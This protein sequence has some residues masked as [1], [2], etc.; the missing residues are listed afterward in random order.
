MARTTHVYR[1]GKSIFVVTMSKTVD[2]L[3]I[4]DEPCSRLPADV[5]PAELGAVVAKS[6]GESRQGVPHPSF[7]DDSH[8]RPLPAVSG[9]K[10]WSTFVKG[11]ELAVVRTE[12]DTV[13]VERHANQGRGFAPGDADPVTS[14]TEDPD[15]LGGAVFRQLG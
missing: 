10:S 7:K 1:R 4:T 2:G 12:G 13:L 5:A 8:L 6:L 14:S 9:L 11:A 3:W 15:G